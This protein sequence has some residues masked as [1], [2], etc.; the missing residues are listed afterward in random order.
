MYKADYDL[1]RDSLNANSTPKSVQKNFQLSSW[2]I[3]REVFVQQYVD[4]SCKHI[5]KLLQK[6]LITWK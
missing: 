1:I 5:A 2:K 3:L 6:I 4:V